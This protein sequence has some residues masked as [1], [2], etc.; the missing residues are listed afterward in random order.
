MNS[1]FVGPVRTFFSD[2]LISFF[3]SM[4]IAA[5][6][7]LCV[8]EPDFLRKK[9]CPKNGENGTKIGFFEFI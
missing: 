5:H 6:V 9:N 2:W 1:L 3:R 4:V 7:V 8:T